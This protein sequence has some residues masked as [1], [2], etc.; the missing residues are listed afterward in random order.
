VDN[1]GLVVVKPGT[2]THVMKLIRTRTSIFL[3][4]GALVRVSKFFEIQSKQRLVA[5]VELTDHSSPFL[6]MF[7]KWPLKSFLTVPYFFYQS[8]V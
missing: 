5:K 6:T 2:V 3:Q 7:G 8:I 4:D 1:A